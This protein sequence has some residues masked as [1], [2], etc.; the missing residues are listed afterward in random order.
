MEVQQALIAAYAQQHPNTSNPYTTAT[1]T[2]LPLMTQS[3]NSAPTYSKSS[4]SSTHTGAIIGG[5]IGGIC[6]ALVLLCICVIVL[7]YADRRKRRNQ[8]VPDKIV[9]TSVLLT[10][11]AYGTAAGAGGSQGMTAAGGSAV[12]TDSVCRIDVD[13]AVSP[14][15]A[16]YASRLS[17]DGI[18]MSSKS[19]KHYSE[20]S[21]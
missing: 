14:P 11:P 18:A 6:A 5:V 20:T 12:Y 9:A 13:G 8:E 16:P 19:V 21:A 1:I 15:M 4:S 2:L 17:E 7:V 3:V 10:T